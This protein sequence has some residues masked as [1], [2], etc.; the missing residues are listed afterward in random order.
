LQFGPTRWG[1]GFPRFVLQNLEPRVTKLVVTIDLPLTAV[2][3]YFVFSERFYRL[4]M[5]GVVVNMRALLIIW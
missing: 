4:P 1:Y 3:A 2:M 5:T